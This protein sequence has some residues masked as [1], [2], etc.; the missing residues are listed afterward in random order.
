MGRN[1][2]RQKKGSVSLFP[3]ECESYVEILLSILQQAT[4]NPDL[5]EAKVY[6]AYP[7]RDAWKVHEKNGDGKNLRFLIQLMA[8]MRLNYSRSSKE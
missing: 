7:V 6:K 8:P 5:L 1:L 4:H 3:D 2:Q